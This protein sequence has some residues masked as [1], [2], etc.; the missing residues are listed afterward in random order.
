MSS[1]PVNPCAE[2]ARLREIQVAIATGE[3]VA[4]TRFGEKEIRY[5]KADPAR[6][7]RLIEYYDRECAISKGEAP[8]RARFAKSMRFRSY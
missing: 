3:A 6:L 5:H 4:S 2:A 1:G 7:D 8:K